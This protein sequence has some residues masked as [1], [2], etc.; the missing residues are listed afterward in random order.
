MA[1]TTLLNAGA[2]TFIGANSLLS[3]LRCVGL[4]T[5][6]LGKHLCELL[7]WDEL[8]GVRFVPVLLL[9]LSASDF[10]G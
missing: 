8:P 4:A 7:R 3:Q 5:F 10:L 6:A 1:E 2:A 9:I